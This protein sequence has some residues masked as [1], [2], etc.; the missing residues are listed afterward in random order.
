MEPATALWFEAWT[1]GLWLSLVSLILVGAGV[2]WIFLST[3]LS[4][5]TELG[6]NFHQPDW[7]VPRWQVGLLVAWGIWSLVGLAIIGMRHQQIWTDMGRMRTAPMIV[8]VVGQQFAW[9]FR[10][11]GPDGKFGRMDPERQSADNPFGTTIGDPDGQDDEVSIG[12]LETTVGVAITF[13][14]RSL[15]VLHSFYLPEF[16][17]QVNAMPGRVSH[18]TVKPSRTGTMDIA[19]NQFCGLGHYRMIARW[20]VVNPQTERRGK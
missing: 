18:I 17:S 3:R 13:Q 14:V 5:K 11:P 10:L 4:G 1:V 16:R 7:E 20:T 19:C 15:D 2:A 9:N 12:E 8:E 6:S